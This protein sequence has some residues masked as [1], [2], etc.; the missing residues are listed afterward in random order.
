MRRSSLL[1]LN[2]RGWRRLA[3]ARIPGGELLKGP[4]PDV[5]RRAIEKK[6]KKKKKRKK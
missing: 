4:E 1:Q 5:N 3:E 2:R 6:K